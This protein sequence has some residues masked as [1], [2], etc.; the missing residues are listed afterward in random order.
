MA[1]LELKAADP[2]AFMN[3]DG[4]AGQASSRMK[5]WPEV[6]SGHGRMPGVACYGSDYSRSPVKFSSSWKMLTKFR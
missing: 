2:F 1:G 4:A 3:I 5:K 6:S